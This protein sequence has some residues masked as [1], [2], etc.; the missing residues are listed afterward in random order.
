MTENYQHVLALAFAVK[1]I[2]E[3]LKILPNVTLGFNIYDNHLIARWTYQ[4]ALQLISPRNKLLPN[5]N[6]D[7]Q[8]TFIALIEG[9]YSQTVYGIPLFFNTHKIPQVCHLLND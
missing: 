9:L 5:Y 7:L 6:C 8:D 3:N 4:A 2:N 1:E